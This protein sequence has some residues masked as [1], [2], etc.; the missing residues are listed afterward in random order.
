METRRFARSKNVFICGVCAGL[1]EYI[2]MNV[3]LM[4]VLWVLGTVFTWFWPSVILYIVLA[5]IM[6]APEG[7][8]QGERFWQNIQGRNVMMVGAMVLIGAGLFIIAQEI[9]HINIQK[10]LF[11]VG[12]VIGGGLLMAYAFGKDRKR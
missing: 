2:G 11:P 7:S 1:A 10:Y 9:F 8:A 12:L 6:A 4:R 3:S 5:F